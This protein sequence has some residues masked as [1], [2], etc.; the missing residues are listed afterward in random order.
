MEISIPDSSQ[1]PIPSVIVITR[2]NGAKTVKYCTMLPKIQ[3][4]PSLENRFA[5]VTTSPE[6]GFVRATPITLKMQPMMAVIRKSQQNRI[7]GG[8]NLL[9]TFSIPSIS[10]ST[11]VFLAAE[12]FRQITERFLRFR[13]SEAT[14]RVPLDPSLSDSLS[15]RWTEMSCGSFRELPEATKIS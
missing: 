8:G 12:N 11:P 6:A 5:D 2:P 14:R 3:S 10:L 7:A 4:T 1:R 9:Q 15:Q 13:E